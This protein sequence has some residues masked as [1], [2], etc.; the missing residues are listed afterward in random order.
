MDQVN[1]LLGYTYCSCGT[2]VPGNQTGQKL[3]FPTINI[4]WQPELK[5]C[6]GVYLVRVLAEGQHAAQSKAGVANYG[7]RP[8]MGQDKDPILEVHLLEGTELQVGDAVTVEWHAFLRREKKFASLE[9]L[10]E[11]IARDKI[12]PMGTVAG[13]FDNEPGNCNA[14]YRAF[15]EARVILLDTLHKPSAPDLLPGIEAIPDFE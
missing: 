2:I 14:F 10:K 7:V 8:T 11:Q 15:S 12:N 6:Y 13:A 1:A 5:P 4:P 3:G 9:A